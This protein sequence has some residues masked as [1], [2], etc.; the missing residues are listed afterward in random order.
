MDVLTLAELQALPRE[1]LFFADCRHSLADLGAGRRAWLAG[2]WPGSVHLHLDADL[3]AP[4]APDLR[5]GR[6]PLPVPAAFGQRA[7]ELGLDRGDRVVAWDDSGGCFAARLWLVLKWLGHD[8]VAVLQGGLGGTA[9]ETG[10]P[11]ARPHGDWQPAP[12][13]GWLATHAEVVARS[14]SGD[15][16]VDCRAPAR[17]RGEV[18]PLDPAAG[19]IPGAVNLYWRDLLDDGV[20]ARTPPVNHPDPVFYCGSGVTACV[21]LLAHRGRTGRGRLYAGSWSGWLAEGG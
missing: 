13:D 15:G 8:D 4:L 19:H 20:L 11:A 9:L 18:E 2:R 1:G 6:H 16:L 5:G 21:S 3:S 14:A 10:A 12:R 7:R 17:Y